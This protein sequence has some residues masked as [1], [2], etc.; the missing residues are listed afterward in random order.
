MREEIERSRE[1]LFAG[2]VFTAARLKVDTE[3]GPADR[4]VV[5]HNGGS[6]VVA[7]NAA[8]EICLVRQYRVAVGRF[9]FELPAGKLEPGEDPEAC[10]R[11]ELSEEAGWEAGRMDFLAL[12]H[13]TPGY[14]SEPINIY[15]T[16]DITEREQHLDADETLEVTVLPFDE[17]VRMAMNGEITDGKTLIGILKVK[18]ILDREEKD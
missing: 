16:R 11:R 15:W 10:A 1:V 6:C 14:S 12:T 9:M 3:T 5:F 13:P 18:A 17:A 2:R 8:G 4:E 7:L